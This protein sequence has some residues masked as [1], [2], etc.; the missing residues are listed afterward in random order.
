LETYLSER[1][2]PGW[3]VIFAPTQER[4]I[5]TAN[6]PDEFA[7]RWLEIE[8]Q[9][10]SKSNLPATDCADLEFAPALVRFEPPE[11]PEHNPE[12]GFLPDRARR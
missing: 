9:D 4:G 6:R 12:H 7:E 8:W 10:G 11:N 5:V 1:L 2:K 3:H